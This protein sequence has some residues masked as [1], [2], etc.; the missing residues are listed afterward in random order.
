M[1]TLR[2][3][4]ETGLYA[5]AISIAGPLNLEPASCPAAKGKRVLDLHGERDENVPI[6]GGVGA[7]G[8]SRVDFKSEQYTQQVFNAAGADFQLQIVRDADHFLNHIGEAIQRDEGQ[9]LQQKVVHYFRLEADTSPPTAAAEST[10]S[11]R[12]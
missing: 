2:M 3:V 4:C 9:S 1:M 8:L 11:R 7:R 6:A 10:P 5:A 12:R